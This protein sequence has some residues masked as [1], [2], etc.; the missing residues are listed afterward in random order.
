MPIDYSNAKIYCIRSPNTDLIYIG[1]T[2]QQ[3]SKRMTNHRA[4]IKFGRPIT[5]KIIFEYGEP[6]IEL[7][8]NF[9]CNNKEELLQKEGEY[10]RTQN[11]C[12]KCIPARTSKEYR[13][14]NKEA[15]SAQKKEYRK[16][17]NKEA[18]AEYQKQYRE[19]NKAYLLEQKKKYYEANK[20][21]I[22]ERMR[23]KK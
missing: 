12:N 10:V 1:S 21:K 16:T 2:C 8:E 17:Q 18:I 15:L 4:N 22:L 5:S 20:D 3:L 6:Y 23:Q 9:P 13:D 19:D 7:L 14:D 11:C